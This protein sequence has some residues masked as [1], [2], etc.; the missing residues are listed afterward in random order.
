[1]EFNSLGEGS[2]IATKNKTIYFGGNKGF[3]RISTQ[4][5]STGE[6]IEQTL[7]PQLYQINIFG[8]LAKAKRNQP[9]NEDAPHYY[10]SKENITYE[11][12]LE[13][14]HDETRFSIS[15]GLINPLYPDLVTYRYKLS[16][17]ENNGFMLIRIVLLNLIIYLLAI[18]VFLSKRKSPENHGQRVEV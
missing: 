14:E 18:I 7:S 10:S 17:F 13:L 12:K 16:D 2:V 9:E 8:S 1:M 15:F 5:Q 3:T 11:E 4:T 6:N